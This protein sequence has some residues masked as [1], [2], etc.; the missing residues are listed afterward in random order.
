MYTLR[1]N[2]NKSIYVMKNKY[3]KKL[4]FKYL[5]MAAQKYDIGDI[6]DIINSLNY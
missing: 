3:I 6:I 4:C 2:K 1:I 5:D